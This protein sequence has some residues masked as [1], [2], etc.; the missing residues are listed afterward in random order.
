MSWPGQLKESDNTA[1]PASGNAETTSSNAKQQQALQELNNTPT[2]AAVPAEQP[3]AAPAPVVPAAAPATPPPAEQTATASTSAS[4][5]PPPA[6]QSTNQAA[7][8]GATPAPYQEFTMSPPM[9]QPPKSTKNEVSA[10]A[11][12]MFGNGKVSLPLG[13][14]LRQEGVSSPQGAFTV[15]R[16]SFYYGGTVSYSYGQAWYIDLSIDQGHSSGNQSIATGFLVD[17]NSSFSIDDTWYH[18]Y[19]KYTFPQL[20]GKRFSAYLRAGATYISA[21]LKDNAEGATSETSPYSQKDDTDDI[22]GNIGFGLGYSLFTTR[23]LRFD[24]Q[25]EGEG[26][27]GE[28]FQQSTESIPADL[29]LTGPQVDINNSLYG[30]IGRATIGMEYRMGSSG[31]FKIFGEVGLEVDY[32]QIQYPGSGTLSEDLWGPYAKLGVRYAF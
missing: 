16:N 11:D 28:R 1:A 17:I 12:M 32:T 24:L 15:P 26:F 2:P 14:S 29:N 21:T 30:G 23:R 8:A 20:R 3:A 5:P 4:V 13:Y 9:L 31:L 27:Y 18:L 22:R 25:V 7:G 6:E 19:L 10:A